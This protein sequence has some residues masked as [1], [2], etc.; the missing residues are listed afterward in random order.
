M[1]PGDCDV[2]LA[3]INLAPLEDGALRWADVVLVGAQ[4][5]QSKSFHAVVERAQA[6]G[7]PVIA[8]GPYPT[9]SPERCADADHLVLGEAE[10]VFPALFAQVRAGAAPKVVKGTRPPLT[11]TPVPRYDLLEKGAYNSLSVQFSRDARFSVSS[12]TSSRSSV[13]S[14]A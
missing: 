7:K 14:L 11:R 12:A 3:D 8:G 10:E 5:A 4:L 1:L 9:T 2:R 6:L 13:A